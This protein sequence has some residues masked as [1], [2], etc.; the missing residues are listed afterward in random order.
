MVD[1]AT[2]VT[3]ARARP[4]RLDDELAAARARIAELEALEADR[5]RSEKIQA[6]LYR[7]AETASAAQ[8]LHEF[9]ASIHVI[10]R[11]LM[12]AENF[13]IALY[14]DDRRAINFPY[15][16]D[17]VDTDVIDPHVWEPFGVGNARGT[18][19]YVLRTGQPQLISPDRHRQLVEQAEI[20][21]VGVV[22]AGDWL[23]V[24]L[25][26]EGQTLGVL[27]VQTYS[28]DE[29]Y[30]QRDVDLLAFVGQHVGVALS[31]ARAIDETRQRN[32]ELAVVNEIGQALAKQLDFDTICELVGERIRSIFET[33]SVTVGLYDAAREV[34]DFKYE[35]D[36]GER[37]RTPPMP[38]G[39][40]LTS[41]VISGRRP[42]RFGT[43][44]D[45]VSHGAQYLGG[46]RSESWLGV[47]ILSGDRVI[48][49]INLESTR[50]HAFGDS[51]ERLLT[52]IAS[53]MG[54]ALENARLFDET[55][56]LLAE[57]DQRAAELAVINEIGQALAKQLDFEA[58]T[59][60]VGERVRQIFD[61]TSLFVA[62]YD[63]PT[64]TIRFPYE[65]GEGERLHTDP[66]E[67][68]PGLTSRVIRSRRP[69][70]LATMAQTEA[71]GA[72]VV[73]GPQ[74][75]SWLGVPILAG[76]HVVGVIGLESLRPDAYTE[77]DER[78]LG[79]LAASMGVALE[80]ARLFD[81]TKRLL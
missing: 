16:V 51:D 33:R 15:Y 4:Q 46:S 25:I 56:H 38:L 28:G 26:S 72:I 44:D 45:L 50:Q 60:L 40:G 36:E 53:S 19:A 35:V 8:D 39:P 7:I 78:L 42:V 70:R 18:T 67:L 3:T 77:A 24:P 61:S 23:G 80:N 12:Y 76:D 57:T 2:R 1:R 10:V 79:T 47:P 30:T 52:T 63:E 6:A 48:G 58:I 75:Q 41:I 5:E 32:A 55:K 21:T 9:Y 81:E 11:G 13:Y 27:T 37:Y 29:R 31:R 34:I 54:V 66:I 71:S 14:D 64:N 43:A 22:A 62:L 59:E 65:I 49:T 74:S 73:E 17:T 20:E 69:L 68:G